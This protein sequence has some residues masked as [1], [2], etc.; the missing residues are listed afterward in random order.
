MKPFDAALLLKYPVA[1][2]H[3]L[4]K[5]SLDDFPSQSCYLCKQEGVPLVHESQSKCQ[6]YCLVDN[7]CATG[8][9]IH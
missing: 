8:T 6:N 5:P 2:K 7:I 1:L 9:V 3:P 4:F